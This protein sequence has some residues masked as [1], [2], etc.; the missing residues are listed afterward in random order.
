MEIEFLTKGQ[1][2]NQ[3][4]LC[5]GTSTKTPNG[6]GLE[7]VYIKVNTQSCW[8]ASATKRVWNLHVHSL[9]PYTAVRISSIW[10]LLSCILYNKPVIRAFQSMMNSSKLQK[11]KGGNS[12]LIASHSEV[13]EVWTCNWHL[14]EGH[15]TRLNPYPEESA[16]TSGREWQ[17]RIDR[18]CPQGQRIVGME[19]GGNLSHFV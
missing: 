11:L 6:W 13:P 2:F 14:K 10:L 15:H 5:S 18:G 3:P 16:K 1:W 12:Q 8:E 19:G 7:S 9:P 17:N 4:C